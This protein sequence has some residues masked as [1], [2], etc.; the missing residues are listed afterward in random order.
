MAA[1]GAG[2]VLAANILLRPVARKILRETASAAEVETHYHVRAVC[3]AKHEQHIRSLLLQ[4]VYGSPMKLRSLH[5]E[6]A[7]TPDRL[8]VRAELVCAGGCDEAMESL[9]SRLSLEQSISAIRWEIV[10]EEEL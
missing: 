3:R 7:E 9:V 6:D 8:E 5:S 2:G 10:A 4:A 1:T